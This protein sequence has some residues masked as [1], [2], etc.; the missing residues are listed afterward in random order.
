MDRGT[1]GLE[2]IERPGGEQAT[3]KVEVKLGARNDSEVEI[4]GG[5]DE[6]SRVLINPP[7]AAENETKL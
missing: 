3:E 6:G 7:S 5:L 2:F 1:V 4:V